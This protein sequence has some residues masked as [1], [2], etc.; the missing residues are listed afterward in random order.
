MTKLLCII[1][2]FIVVSVPCYAQLSTPQTG[3]SAP[4]A[5]KF[6]R[7][8]I[9]PRL[10]FNSEPLA[11]YAAAE[12]NKSFPDE[13][14]KFIITHTGKQYQVAFLI[15]IMFFERDQADAAM[16]FLTENPM[17]DATKYEIRVVE[18]SS[19]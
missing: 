4:P 18:D 15:K 3:M 14:Y 10:T 17:W 13:S 19:Y 6:F 1:L 2:T 9:V 5:L 8:A 12:L 11:R 7:V 16:N